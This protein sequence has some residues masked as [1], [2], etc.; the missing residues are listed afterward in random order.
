MEETNATSVTTRSVGM[1]Y[2]MILAVIS[3]VYFLILTL[4]G[5][6]MTSG[7]GRW[8]S[9]IFY[10][11]IIFLAH[12]NYKENGNGYMSYGQGMGISFWIGLISSVIYSI[13]FYLYVKFIDTSFVQMIKDKQIEEMQNRGMSEEQ[14]NQAMKFAD[15][16]TSPEAMFLFGLIGGIIF[17]LI[18]GLIV[19]IFTQKNNPETSI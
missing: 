11:V 16:F 6:D 5:V 4:S 2:G 3:V 19:S 14:I 17:I 7:I 18:V 1:R 13:F 12:K 15:A 10:F 8:S 9:I